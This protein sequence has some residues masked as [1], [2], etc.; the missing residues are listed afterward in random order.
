MPDA[1]REVQRASHI[2]VKCVRGRGR[3]PV[4]PQSTI[5]EIVDL[6][7]NSK[8]EGQ[9]HWSVRTMAAMVGANP[10]PGSF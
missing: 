3:K 6:T 9:T 8:P 5:D 4:V 7:R 1:H 10:G 2:W